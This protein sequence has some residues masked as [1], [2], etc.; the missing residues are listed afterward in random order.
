MYEEFARSFLDTCKVAWKSCT[1]LEATRLWGLLVRIALP[2]ALTKFELSNWASSMP[3]QA[4]IRT[5]PRTF[6]CA[7]RRC[8]KIGRPNSYPIILP[9][10]ATQAASQAA[11]QCNHPS[12]IRLT[13]Y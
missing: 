11:S 5:P 12:M 4:M 1:D 8:R 9:N 7:G 6:A 3:K 2:T 13:V 10:A